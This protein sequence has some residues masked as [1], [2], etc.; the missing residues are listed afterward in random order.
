MVRVRCSILMAGL[1]ATAFVLLTGRGGATA[2]AGSFCERVKKT[3]SSDEGQ[4]DRPAKLAPVVWPVI[5]PPVH[6]VKGT[7]G[8]IHL[9]Y[10]ILFTNVVANAVRIQSVEMID[11]DEDECP[12]ARTASSPSTART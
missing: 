12:S 4:D 5:G 6:P 11:P 2:F 10:E 7:D 1:A 8:R 3:C 9:A